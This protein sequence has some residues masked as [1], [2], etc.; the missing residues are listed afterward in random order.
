MRLA[1]RHGTQGEFPH[2]GIVAQVN[3]VVLGICSQQLGVGEDG[4]N[5]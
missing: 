4:S 3:K 1:L 2:A 5:A